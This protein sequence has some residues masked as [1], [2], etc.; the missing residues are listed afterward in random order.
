VPK[1]YIDGCPSTIA[2]VLDGGGSDYQDLP[3]GYSSMES[4]YLAVIFGLNSY[5]LKW[6][7]ELDARQYD[8][9]LESKGEF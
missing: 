3:S 6:Q 1:L 8:M 4:E 2:Y 7:K 9:S 5:F